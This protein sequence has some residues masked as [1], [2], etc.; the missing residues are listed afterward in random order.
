MEYLLIG[1][2][3][4]FFL[5]KFTCIALFTISMWLNFDAY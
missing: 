5:I 2:F 4:L 3:A 1:A